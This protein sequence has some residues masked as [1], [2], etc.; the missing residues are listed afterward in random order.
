MKW[1]G[2]KTSMKYMVSLIH[3]ILPNRPLK[4][5][6]GGYITQYPYVYVRFQNTSGQ[7]S[8]QTNDSFYSNNQNAEGKTFR[9]LISNTVDDTIT[10]FVTLAAGDILQT[11][12]FSLDENID[13]SVFLPDG[14]LFETVDQETPRPDIPNRDIQISALFSLT[15]IE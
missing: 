3:L 14:S 4:N 1:G 5:G 11:Q 6:K 8:I 9:V 15:N 7:G 10:N 2:Y 12:T 13:F